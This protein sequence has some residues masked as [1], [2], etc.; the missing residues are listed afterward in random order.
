MGEINKLTEDKLREWQIRRMD[1]KDQ[2]VAYPEKT[3]ELSKMLDLMDD[4]HAAILGEG[5]DNRAQV[6]CSQDH[7]EDDC[8]PAGPLHQPVNGRFDLQLR[9]SASS[10]EDLRR[11]LDMAVFELQSKIDAQ[12]AGEIGAY[13]RCLGR[14]SG[15]LGDY[16]FE[17]CVDGQ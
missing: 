2:M 5:A 14:M 16:H 4:E 12:G 13:D 15:S 17:L 11:L 7:A 10:P 1:V 8:V 3:L 9:V 6:S